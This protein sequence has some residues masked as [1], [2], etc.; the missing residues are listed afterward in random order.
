[1]IEATYDGVIGTL[2][3]IF[4]LIWLPL[5]VMTLLQVGADCDHGATIILSQTADMSIVH[6]TRNKALLWT[7]FATIPWTLCIAIIGRDFLEP[8]TDTVPHSRFYDP[9]VWRIFGSQLLISFGAAT[10]MLLLILVLYLTGAVHLLAKA[11]F[12]FAVFFPIIACM[13]YLCV[14]LGWQIVPVSIAEE[15]L[16]LKRSWQLTAGQFWRCFGLILAM[17]VPAELL[18]YLVRGGIFLTLSHNTFLLMLGQIMTGTRPLDIVIALQLVLWIAAL[19]VEKLFLI[20]L[21]TKA[22]VLFYQAIEKDT[23]E[24]KAQDLRFASP[25]ETHV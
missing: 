13:L 12:V 24:Q 6:A 3:R 1:M 4:R 9:A 19:F 15:N 22:Q 21:L 2:G 17:S 25:K 23:A 20:G 8:E 5:L 14:R 16:G 18:F 11:G 10:A 7:V